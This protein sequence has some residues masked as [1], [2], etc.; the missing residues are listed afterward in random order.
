MPS[1]L[2]LK[3]RVKQAASNGHYLWRSLTGEVKYDLYLEHHTRLHPDCTPM[4]EKEFWRDQ[5]DWNEA[6]V[7]APCC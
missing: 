1:S 5:A 2:E 7:Q 6:N 3:L 4:T